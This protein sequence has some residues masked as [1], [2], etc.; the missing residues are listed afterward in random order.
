M[1]MDEQY[2]EMRRFTD[3]LTQFNTQLQASMRDLQ[4]QHEYIDPYWQDEMRRTYDTYWQPLDE[5]MKNYLERE[6]PM[7]TDF[8]KRKIRALEAYLYGHR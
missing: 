1:S 5:F 8:L 4:T 2:A 6:E 3:A 7:Y